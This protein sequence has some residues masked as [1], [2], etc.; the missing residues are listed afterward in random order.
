MS[1][2]ASESGHFYLPDG[3]PY[4]TVKRAD[5]K[6][7]RAATLR[8]ARKVGAYI[9]TTTVI[10]CAAAPQLERWKRGKVLL[11]GLTL[12]HIEGES[13]EDWLSRVEADW[14]KEG[15]DAAEGGTILHGVIE[16]YYRG[17]QYDRKWSEWVSA[18]SDEVRS[19]CGEQEW[20]AERSFAHPKGYGGKTD[21]HC[22][23]WV[24]D[25][26]SKEGE[27][28]DKNCTIYDEHLM[29]GAAY[30]RGL[31]VPKARVGILF[32]SRDLPQAKLVEIPE[33]SLV[34]GLAMFDALLAY[35][36]AKNSYYPK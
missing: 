34:K 6:G 7:D 20:S 33:E 13:E 24:N 15:K 19:K 31:N 30:R 36:Q 21:L 2:F 8:D 9:G 32:V 17:D 12:P 4:Y 35:Y 22:A 16:Q 10:K 5:G 3:T 18:V 26:K 27:L 14:Q 11:A 25:Y 28:T 23:S 1:D 29:Q